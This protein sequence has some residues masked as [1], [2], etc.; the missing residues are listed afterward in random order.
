MPVIVDPDAC[1]HTINGR[2]YLRRVQDNGGVVVGGAPYYVGYGYRGQ[3][4]ALVVDAP[5]REFTVVRAGQ[6]LKRLPIK[7][8][9]GQLLPF[10]AFVDLL[11]AQARECMRAR[12]RGQPA[13]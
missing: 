8:L 2:G 5:A 3:E 13:L 1:L 4:V 9:L 10:D 6:E 7:G 11:A 12:C